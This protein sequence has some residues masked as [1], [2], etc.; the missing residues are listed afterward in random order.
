MAEGG[1]AEGGWMGRRRGGG[2]LHGVN[3]G[4]TTMGGRRRAG[5]QA[6]EDG[7][8]ERGD[9]VEMRAGGSWMPRS[10]RRRELGPA[11]EAQLGQRGA[12]TV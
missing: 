10:R 2:G 5:S 11:H 7:V 12:A 1:E 4:S 3:K 6:V 8:G 9:E